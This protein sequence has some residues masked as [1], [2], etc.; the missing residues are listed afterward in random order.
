[1]KVFW[2]GIALWGLTL[3][4]MPIDALGAALYWIGGAVIWTGGVI[5]VVI[6]SSVWLVICL[7][8][9]LYFWT[10][11]EEWVREKDFSDE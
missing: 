7:L 9:S 11:V 4:I 1:M 10:K 2:L 3:S 5:L 6:G 8:A